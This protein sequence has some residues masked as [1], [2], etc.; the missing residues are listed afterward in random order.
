MP[1]ADGA[2]GAM[3]VPNGARDKGKALNRDDSLKTTGLSDPKEES[4]PGRPAPKSKPS[5]DA[6][7]A[8]TS[9]QNTKEPAKKAGANTGDHSNGL[10]WA[11]LM[12]L[13]LAGMIRVKRT[14]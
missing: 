14:M 8:K 10:M 2:G 5:S 7:A 6:G 11:A 9:S 13:A 1:G 4:V 12:V 3:D